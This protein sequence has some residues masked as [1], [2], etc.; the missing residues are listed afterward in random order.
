MSCC[1]QVIC[2]RRWLEASA[3]QAFH[4]RKHHVVAETEGACEVAAKKMEIL[5]HQE[6]ELMPVGAK[7]RHMARKLQSLLGI[8]SAK[9]NPSKRKAATKCCSR[10][11]L[12]CQK[13]KAV[14]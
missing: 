7:M 14:T 6:Q 13:R 9:G 4:N 11:N 10:Q 5:E 2:L 3:K 8:E 1:S 12:D